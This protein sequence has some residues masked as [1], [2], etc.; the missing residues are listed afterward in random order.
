[1]KKLAVMIAIASI[2]SGC[3][4]KDS[5]NTLKKLV[6]EKEI[7]DYVAS[8]YPIE[9]LEIDLLSSE[10]YDNCMDVINIS[11]LSLVK[12]EL[13]K[14]TRYVL[15]SSVDTKPLKKCVD[16]YLAKKPV[17]NDAMEALISNPYYE[18]YKNEPDVREIINKAKID[19]LIT[20]HEQK[21]ILDLVRNKRLNQALAENKIWYQK[22]IH[23]L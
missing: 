23:D 22:Q 1:M 8:N 9:S 11:Q 2:L 19:N 21:E 5:L 14:E 18:K 16:N 7:K 13:N 15:K 10:I 3:M 20:Y 17:S 4:T 6:V 12:I